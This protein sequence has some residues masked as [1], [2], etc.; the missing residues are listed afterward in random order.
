LNRAAFG[1]EE[2]AQLVDRLRRAGLVIAA[3]VAAEDGEVVGHILLSDLWVETDTGGVVRTAALAP[4]AVAPDRQRRGIGSRLVDAG[5]QACR[6]AG[7]EL[8]VVLGHPGY[9]PRFGFSAARARHLRAPFSGPAFMALELTPGVLDGVR[10]TVRYPDAFGLE[11][12]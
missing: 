6:D 11:G 10:A 9:Y 12:G 1:G 4:M 7:I 3:L 8:V 5:L 2:E